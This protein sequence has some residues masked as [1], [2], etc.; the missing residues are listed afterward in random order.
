MNRCGC[1]LHAQEWCRRRGVALQ[2]CSCR[3]CC[4]ENLQSVSQMPN[5]LVAWHTPGSGVR[6]PEQAKLLSPR[7]THLEEAGCCDLVILRQQ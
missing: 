6:V 2:G 5:V 4:P 1:G 7:Y 3:G